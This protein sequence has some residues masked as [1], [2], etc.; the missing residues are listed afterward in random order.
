VKKISGSGYWILLVLV[1]VF[2][3]QSVYQWITDRQGFKAL[4]Y[5]SLGFGTIGFLAMLY[6][7]IALQKAKKKQ[8]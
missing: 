7:T 2:P 4:D 5:I 3:L 6:L 1:A 8:V